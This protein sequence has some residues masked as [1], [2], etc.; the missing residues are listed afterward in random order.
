VCDCACVHLNTAGLGIAG[1]S[2]CLFLLQVVL[3]AY[4]YCR[5]FYVRF[6]IVGVYVPIFICVILVGSPEVVA[7]DV[8]CNSSTEVWR[9]CK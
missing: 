7:N 6:F 1:G 4:S 3:C 5:W 9:N 8:F 2:M